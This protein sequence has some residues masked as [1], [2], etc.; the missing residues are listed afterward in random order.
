MV[1]RW[2]EWVIKIRLKVMEGLGRTLE[3]W[4]GVRLMG[5]KLRKAQ[6]GRRKREQCLQMLGGRRKPGVIQTACRNP[7][8]W[9]LTASGEAWKWEWRRSKADAECLRWMHREG[10]L[11]G[12]GQRASLSVVSDSLQHHGLLPA[13]FPCLWNSPGT[14]TGV[15]CH[16]L[17][18]EI[19]LIRDQTQVS[20][21]TGRFSTNWA[22][23]EAL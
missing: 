22:S 6:K 3:F 7:R 1:L 20:C 19:F 10:S 2:H 8:N 4:A 13:K 16:S 18:R 23:R 11:T 9:R 21:T 5:Y 12:S 15:G 14:D 17:L